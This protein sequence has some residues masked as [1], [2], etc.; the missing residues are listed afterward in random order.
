[1]PVDFAA[2]ETFVW[3]AARL[4]DR[5]RYAM[6]FAGGPAEPVATALAPYQNA[7]GG[8]GHA[9]EPDLRCPGSQP[10]ATL[11]ALEMLHEAGLTDTDMARRARGVDRLGRRAGRRDPVRA[12]RLRAVSALSVVGARSPELVPHDGAGRGPPREQGHR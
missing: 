1:M 7:D 3:S 9:L 11:Y 8:F 5:H 6:L 4:V 2:A 12:A 10:A